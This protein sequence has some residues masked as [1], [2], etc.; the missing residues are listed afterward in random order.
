MLDPNQYVS[1]TMQAFAASIDEILN[2]MDKKI[3]SLEI[4]FQ[5]NYIQEKSNYMNDNNNNNNNNNI[6]N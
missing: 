3:T 1:K 6:L 4:K 5:N 2:Y